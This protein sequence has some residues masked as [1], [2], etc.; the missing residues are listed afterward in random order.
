MIRWM[1]IV[2]AAFVAAFCL[3]YALQN[4]VN[5]GQAYGFVAVMVGMEGQEAYPAHIGPAV[6]APFL[7]WTMLWIIIVAE[8]TAGVLA[9]RGSWDLFRARHGDA[10][11]FQAARR[12]AVMGAGLGGDSLVRYLRRHWRRLLP[13]VA[14]GA[15]CR[16]I[17][18]RQPVCSAAW[19]GAAHSDDAGRVGITR[20]ALRRPAP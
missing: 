8:L 12:F 16:A 10:A 7:I 13:D 18:R 11:Q 20:T 3:L 17:A 4:I 1:K 5:L 14:D 9:A 19:R 6:E 2:L 15:R